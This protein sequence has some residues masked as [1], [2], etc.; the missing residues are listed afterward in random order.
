MLKIEKMNLE[1]E[2]A[3]E[4]QRQ[5]RTR[6]HNAGIEEEESMM[7]SRNSNWTD[8]VGYNYKNLKFKRRNLQRCLLND[9]DDI[10][11]RNTYWKQTK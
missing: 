1:R 6:K 2:K 3:K 7:T 8:Q 11:K 10:E 9:S 4:R 5:C